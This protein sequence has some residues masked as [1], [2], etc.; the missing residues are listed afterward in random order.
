MSLFLFAQMGYLAQNLIC[1]NQTL[2]L[3]LRIRST[4]LLRNYFIIHTL[5]LSSTYTKDY[6]S[7]VLKYAAFWLKLRKYLFARFSKIVCASS[8]YLKQ[9]T[10]GINFPKTAYY[11]GCLRIFNLISRVSVP[12]Q[13]WLNTHTLY[14]TPISIV[15]TPRVRN[16]IKCTLYYMFKHWLNVWAS[17][18]NS[19]FLP[20]SFTCT[21]LLWQLITFTNVFYFKVYNT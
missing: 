5:V 10:F 18:S 8:R 4:W 20:H 3:N 11:K 9:V 16:L 13:P 21:S 17:I 19:Y 15:T 2:R 7:I 1:T 14:N 6:T 12:Q